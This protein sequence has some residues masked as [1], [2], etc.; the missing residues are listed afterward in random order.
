MNAADDIGYT[1]PDYIPVN[2]LLENGALPGG[3]EGRRI[4]Y[5]SAVVGTG[6]EVNLYNYS[7]MILK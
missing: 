4:R 7:I 6:A 5:D 2:R 3:T 1:A